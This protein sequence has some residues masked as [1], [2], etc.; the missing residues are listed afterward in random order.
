MV[1]K[2]NESQIASSG[3]PVRPEGHPDLFWYRPDWAIIVGKNADYSFQGFEYL[4]SGV[5]LSRVPLSGSLL[6]GVFNPNEEATATIAKAD[7]ISAALNAQVIADAATAK[8]DAETAAANA[9]AAAKIIAE[10]FA[11]RPDV[12]EISDIQ[13][14]SNEKYFDEI[15]KER[16]KIVLKVKNSSKIKEDVTGV[17][18]RIYQPKGI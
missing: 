14:I 4:N 15:G 1:S 16:A 18:A 13:I 3:R 17:D 7:A 11:P 9:A 6:A 5:P 8:K 12:P 10:A 2:I